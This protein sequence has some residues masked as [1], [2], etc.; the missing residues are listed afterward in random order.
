M[1]EIVRLGR[2][3]FQRARL[4]RKAMTAAWR[5]ETSTTFERIWVGAMLVSLVALLASTA[6]L[7]AFSP[8]FRAAGHHDVKAAAC[9]TGVPRGPR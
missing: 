8:D 2:A 1:N 7:D 9:A 3:H 5:R 6:L 4:Q